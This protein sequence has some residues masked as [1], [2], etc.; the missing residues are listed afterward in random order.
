M[1]KALGSRT[2]PMTDTPA[3]VGLKIFVSVG[4]HEQGF[5][6]LLSAVVAIMA[7][8]P[9]TT[10]W[11]IQTGPAKVYYPASVEAQPA[12]SHDEMLS[13]LAWADAMISQASPG[14]VFTA[15]SASTQPIVVARNRELS[16]HVDNHQA[17]FAEYLQT[18]H[19]AMVAH[20]ASSLSGHLETLRLEQPGARR[21]RL[22]QLCEA[23]QE[24]TRCWVTKFEDAISELIHGNKN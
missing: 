10:R 12:Y 4:T 9:E 5:P 23:S 19:L 14:N 18:N 13:N 7:D 2:K 22:T 8:Q 21:E 24:R 1:A 17:I 20:D 16:E 15:L 3:D 6:R 11:R